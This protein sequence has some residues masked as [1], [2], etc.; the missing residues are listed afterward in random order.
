MIRRINYL[1]TPT[2]FPGETGMFRIIST[3]MPGDLVDLNGIPNVW[4]KGDLFGY[5]FHSVPL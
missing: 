3:C 4:P 2:S 5:N 1:P